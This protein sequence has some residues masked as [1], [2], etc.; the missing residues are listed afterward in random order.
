VGSTTDWLHEKVGIQY[1]PD[2]HQLAEYS[3]D[4]ELAYTG[5]GQ[6]FAKT[7]RKAIDKSNINVH[8]DTRVTKLNVDKEGR[9]TGIEA[10]SEN[11]VTFK[12]KAKAIILGTGGYGNNKDLLT[13][14]LE[15]VLYYG[16]ASSTGDG[17]L[18]TEDKNIN[19]DRRL[20]EY[21]KTYP[22]GVEV[23]KGTA[24][25][26]IAGNIIVFKENALLLNI[27]G[28]RV[29]NEKASNRQILDTEL[30]QSKKMLYLFMDQAAF[31]QFKPAV[32]EAGI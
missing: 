10:K 31:D 26:T 19:A 4:R 7:A 24:K 2:L 13:D 21:G 28:K 29:V 11:G 6:G 18:L 15:K 16:P 9:I 23:A 14:D 12:V 5:G 32:A 3:H 22:N 25:S 20:M 17:L 8:L 1:E 27:K 30:S